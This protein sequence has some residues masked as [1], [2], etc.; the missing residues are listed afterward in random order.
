MGEKPKASLLVCT[1]AR[2]G[3]ELNKQD[4]C[5]D[6]ECYYMPNG[7]G[8]KDLLQVFI[9]DLAP[10]FW[11]PCYFVNQFWFQ[12]NQLFVTKHLQ[13]RDSQ[14]M[15][16]FLWLAVAMMGHVITCG[17]LCLVCGSLKSP[18]ASVDPYF[19]LWYSP[20]H[21]PTDKTFQAVGFHQLPLL[22]PQ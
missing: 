15:D 5:D 19:P 13:E 11:F 2:S 4:I 16:V 18:T 21:R 6:T 7:C 12:W 17:C 9:A 22:C 20:W 10:S 3:C 8:G 14:S 1:T